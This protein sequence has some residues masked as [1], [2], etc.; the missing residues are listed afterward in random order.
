MPSPGTVMQFFAPAGAGVR[1]DSHL[2]PNYAIPTF[3]DSLIGK[4]A[5]EGVIKGRNGIV[6]VKMRIKPHTR[7]SGSKKLHHCAR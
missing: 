3:Y 6:R 7:T 1:F 5:D 4:L 2:Y